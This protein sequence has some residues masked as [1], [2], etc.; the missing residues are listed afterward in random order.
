MSY[1]GLCIK[2]IENNHK[3][4]ILTIIYQKGPLTC[5][6]YNVQMAKKV[7]TIAA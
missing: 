1:E 5:F 3:K 4:N 7:Q 2:F 6:A